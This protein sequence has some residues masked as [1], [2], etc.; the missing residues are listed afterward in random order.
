[1][2]NQQYTSFEEA[3]QDIEEAV[4]AA[5]SQYDNAGEWVVAIM[6]QVNRCQFAAEGNP[7]ANEGKAAASVVKYIRNRSGQE[8]I[9]ALDSLY[10]FIAE[11][12]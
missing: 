6:E 1:M 5:A 8:I 12:K 4:I 7:K 11:W 9:N 2:S 10:Y 3:Q